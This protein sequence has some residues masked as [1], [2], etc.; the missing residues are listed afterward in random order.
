MSEYEIREPVQKRSIEKKEKIIESGFE[1]ICEKGYYRLLTENTTFISNQDSM[2][3]CFVSLFWV[4]KDALPD[5]PTVNLWV[6]YLS[7]HEN[8]RS[9]NI[10]T[11]NSVT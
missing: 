2:F 1:L 4:L 7:L 10:K 8:Y 6:P 3:V 5:C 11:Y 9:T